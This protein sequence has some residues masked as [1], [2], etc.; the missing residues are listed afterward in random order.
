MID[1]WMID[2]QIVDRYVHGAG[3]GPKQV[4]MPPVDCR[5]AALADFDEV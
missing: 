1:K 4:D 2:R 3:G 5:R